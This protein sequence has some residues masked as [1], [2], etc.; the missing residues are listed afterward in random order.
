VDEPLDE[1]G[2]ALGAPWFRR[3]GLGSIGHD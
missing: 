1:L 2:P 3:C